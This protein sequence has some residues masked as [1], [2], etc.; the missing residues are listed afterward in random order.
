[1]KKNNRWSRYDFDQKVLT[2]LAV[3]CLALAG[4]GAYLGFTGDSISFIPAVLMI[5]EVVLLLILVR[6]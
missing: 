2:I 5:V 6:E 4:W 3:L 1:V